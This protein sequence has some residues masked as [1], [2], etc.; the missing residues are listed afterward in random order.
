MKKKLNTQNVANAILW[1]AAILS[2]A[3]LDAITY[4]N[5]FTFIRTIINYKCKTMQLR[6]Y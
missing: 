4:Y 1:S 6:E 5:Y 2:S 3:I